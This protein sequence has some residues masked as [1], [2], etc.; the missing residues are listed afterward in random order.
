LGNN[1]QVGGQVGFAGHTHVGNN[2]IITAQS[3]TSHDVEPGAVLSGSPAINNI[4]WL[5]SVAAFPKL[6]NTIRR[7]RQL[8]KE[9]E[10]LKEIVKSDYNK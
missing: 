1:I 6:P 9:I 10:R 3:G 7:L 4:E 2:A 5:R 8:E